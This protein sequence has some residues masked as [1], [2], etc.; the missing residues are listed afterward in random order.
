MESS[1]KDFKRAA[2]IASDPLFVQFPKG[3]LGFLYLACGQL[4]EAENISKSV[5]NFC[6]KHAIGLISETARLSLAPTLIAKG[7]L[8][9]GIRM[10]EQTQQ[11]L[12]RNQRRVACARVDYIL[13]KVYSQIATGPPPAFS[14]MAKNLNF[15]VKYVPFAGKKA[16]EHFKKAIEVFREIGAKGSLGPV[17]LDL[18]LLYKAKKR[19]D[20][21]RECILEAIKAFKECESEAYLKRAKDALSSLE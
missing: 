21:A 12:I 17:Y 5:L 18:G 19:E 16:E 10:L 8:M 14:I 1:K 13:G 20:Q 3:Q 7:H 11:T 2:E 15:L 9:Q 4:N 6:D